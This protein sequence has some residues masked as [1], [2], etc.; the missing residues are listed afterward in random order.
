ME[1]SLCSD[2]NWFGVTVK[3]SSSSTR[4]KKQD[5]DNANKRGKE[6]K[7]SKGLDQV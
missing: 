5:G 6:A 7:L 2:G 4:E 1:W 3:S